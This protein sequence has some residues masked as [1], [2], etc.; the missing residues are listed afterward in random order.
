MA[1]RDSAAGY[2]RR[3]VDVLNDRS[4][5]I[6]VKEIR[7]SIHSNVFIVMF[8]IVLLVNIIICL[9][10]TVSSMPIDADTSFGK[11]MFIALC[12]AFSFVGFL[13]MPLVALLEMQRERTSYTYEMLRITNLSTGRIVN[14]KLLSSYVQLMLYMSAFFPFM[15]FTYLARGITISQIVTGFIY[16]SIVSFWMVM[17]GI[18]LGTLGRSRFLRALSTLTGLGIF[19]LFG[20]WALGGFFASDFLSDLARD[21]LII[22]LGIGVVNLLFTFVILYLSAVNQ[23]SSFT[24]SCSR[25]FR[26]SSLVYT[27]AAAGSLIAGKYLLHKHIYEEAGFGVIVIVVIWWCVMFLFSSGEEMDV[28]AALRKKIP[29][30]PPALTLQK[31]LIPGGTRGYRLSLYM[32]AL[33][34]GGGVLFVSKYMR[35]GA[36]ELSRVL[37]MTACY[38]LFYV[39]M[40]LVISRRFERKTEI[41][42]M[43]RRAIVII[44]A[45]AV[46][47]LTI[48]VHLFIIMLSERQY[49]YDDLMVIQ[50]FNPVMGTVK[51]VEDGGGVF[52]TVICFASAG[53]LM[54]VAWLIR[55]HTEL[56]KTIEKLKERKRNGNPGDS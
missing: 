55:G 35:H 46:S 4:N 54:N 53:I 39:S 32:I 45:G 52:W 36:E 30:K 28:P 44:L 8:M 49:Q 15:M 12:C 1:V 48:I 10:G 34:A 20:F 31:L 2:V 6:L 17:I 33:T 18:V 42:P 50:I 3:F 26:I 27:A 25:G 37:I 21:A 14:G 43:K 19:C 11:E 23:L 29:L 5:P 51:A 56:N 40:G 22:L 9:V 24:T 38:T 7:Q 41:T 16:L 47:V 13:F